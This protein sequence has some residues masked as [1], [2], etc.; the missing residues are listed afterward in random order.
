MTQR[1][2]DS[3]ATTDA[4]ADI[5][6]DA[7]LLA[8]MLDFE[9]AL[10]RIEARLGVIPAAAA[11]AIAAAADAQAFDV[12]AIARGARKSGTIA[13]PFVDALRARVR[14]V[15]ADAST[16]VHW[17][18][19]SQD[20]TDTAFVRC[21]VRAKG[22]LI[23][24]HNRLVTALQR[25]SDRH[26]TT[27]MLARTLMQP[28]P[29]TTFGL[30][31]AGWLGAVRRSGARLTASF[32]DACLL[33]FGGASGTLAALGDH[34]PAIAAE[35]ARELGLSNPGAPWHAHRDRMAALAAACGIYTGVLAKI[36]RDITLLMQDE[37]GEAA[38]P[39]GSS[40]SMPQKRNPAG[41][42]IAIAAAIRVPGL[43]AAFLAAMPQE[44][45]RAVGGWHAEM[46]TIAAIVQATGSALAAVVESIEH[47]HVDAVRMRANIAATHGTVFAE[48]AMMLLAP[49]VGRDAAS[50][51]IASAVEAARGGRQTF[52]TALA[53]SARNVAALTDVDLSDL[54]N[55]DAYVGAADAF[56][57]RLIEGE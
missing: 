37:V 50:T 44:H 17:G 39:G 40:S 26:A 38:E 47:L 19:T 10:A 14:A 6:S 30:K 25:L 11:D 29:P 5:F 33:Q 20:V 41:C 4:L 1:L 48:R 53:A 15:D 51:L 31:A 8:A 2:I 28:A 23:A 55:P 12:G 52:G 27:V 36:A 42:A 34:G 9:V 22:A 45:E 46:P 43:V 54:D 21:L 13:I 18:A 32:D 35:L 3:L 7:A 56:R 16:F 57:R 24:D 49:I